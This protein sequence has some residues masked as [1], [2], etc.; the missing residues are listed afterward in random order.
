MST[1]CKMPGRNLCARNGKVAALFIDVDGTILECQP[2][3]DSAVERFGFLM[4]MLGFDK[5]H[6]IATLREI[7][8][9][10]T[11][12]H[13]FERDRFPTSMVAAYGRLCKEKKLRR[14]REVTL[15]CEDIGNSPFFRQPK[16]FANAASVLGRAHHNFLMIAVTIGNREAQK[17]KIRQGGLDPVFDEIIVT[18]NDDKAERVR[19]A[20]IDLNIDAELSAFIGNS[21]R[22]DG[23]CLTET[24]FIYLP[25]EKGW[26]FDDTDLPAN[27][28]HDTFSV[29]DWREAED[30]AIT[31]LLRKREQMVGLSD[32]HDCSKHSC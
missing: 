4:A 26:S 31:R 32:D 8:L 5:K 29:K 21:R 27:T 30:R 19:E 25:L 20:I 16:L 7:D 17:Y 14:R 1:K 6:A 23:A 2:Y 11:H 9:G 24:N 15:I 3:F 10:S 28:G 18:P 13:G 12:T 22:S